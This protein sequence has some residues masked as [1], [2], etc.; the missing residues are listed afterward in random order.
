MEFAEELADI[1][2]YLYLTAERFGINLPLAILEKVEKVNKR[3][4]ESE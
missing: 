1:F 3:R 2:I 4:E